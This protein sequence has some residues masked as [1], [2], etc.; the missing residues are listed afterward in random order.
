MLIPFRPALLLEK[1]EQLQ[2]SFKNAKQISGKM[3]AVSNQNR[4]ESQDDSSQ[5]TGVKPNNS[6][7]A[8]MLSLLRTAAASNQNEP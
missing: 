1:N 7:E 4:G 3:T 8:K 6:S 5:V 2:C